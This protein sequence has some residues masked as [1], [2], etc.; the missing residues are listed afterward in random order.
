MTTFNS[1]KR[2][3]KIAGSAIATAKLCVKTAAG[4]KVVPC[5]VSGEGVDFIAVYTAGSGE[6]VTCEVP[7]GI[8]L[9]TAGAAIADNAEV[10]VDTTGKVITYAASAGKVPC[11]KLTE[12]SSAAAD[13][14]VVSIIFY[15]KAQSAS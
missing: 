2:V 6:P 4:D 15:T 3:S 1:L 10:M 5:S 11:G 14:D 13:L 9:V 12:G 8:V 7:G